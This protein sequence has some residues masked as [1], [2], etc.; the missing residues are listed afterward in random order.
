M[1]PGSL[2][3]DRKLAM[4]L[5]VAGLVLCA[6]M[7]HAT[8]NALLRTQA[9]RL[10]LVTVMSFVSTVIGLPFAIAMPLPPS[11]AWPYLLVSAAVQVIYTLFLLLCYRVADLGSV[12]PVIRG[13]VPLLVSLGAAVFAGER[14]G[15]PSLLGIG[16]VSFGI[17]AMVLGQ[18]NGGAKALMPAF[19]TGAVIA[20]YTV[21]DGVGVRLTGNSISYTAWI[22]VVYGTLVPVV[23]LVARGR[24]VVRGRASEA[25]VATLAGAGQ[26]ATY[27]IVLWAY[28]LSPLGPVS[29]LRETS[30]VFAALIG[31]RFLG[32]RLTAA[33]LGACAAI[34][35]GA[36]CL[37]YFAT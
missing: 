1:L 30:V 10:W 25:R 36:C 22:F 8:W 26:L 31:W 14:P 6:A 27:A 16:L 21:L 37:S 19:A 3:P 18:Q 11:A 15:L 24:L 33:R 32:E 20:T 34:A 4:S 7:L 5:S 28:R 13:S 23:Y 29:A 2:V 35:T 12:Y 9:D 17:M